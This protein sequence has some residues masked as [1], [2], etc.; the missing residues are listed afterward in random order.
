M[1][2]LLKMSSLII[3]PDAK[4]N[5]RIGAEQDTSMSEHIEDST[6][7]RETDNSAFESI[8]AALKEGELSGEPRHLD[9][10]SF[11]AR[12]MANQG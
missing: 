10:I 5:S 3:T 12:M 11:K 1:E 7:H 9:V 6:L 4:N 8:C 2:S